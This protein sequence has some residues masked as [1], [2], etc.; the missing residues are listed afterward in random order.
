[1]SSVS[2]YPSFTEL[3]I[4]SFWTKDPLKN[5]VKV[6]DSFHQRPESMQINP[7]PRQFKGLKNAPTSS[8]DPQIQRPQGKNSHSTEC[9]GNLINRNGAASTFLGTFSKRLSSAG[10]AHTPPGRG[11]TD[12]L[13]KE[14]FPLNCEG[15]VHSCSND[16]N[17]ERQESWRTWKETFRVL[18]SKIKY[19]FFYYYYI[20]LSNWF[21]GYW[22][23]FM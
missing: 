20:S 1:M 12:A 15:F 23:S 19:D 17:T 6:K 13:H 10:D 11:L 16:Y 3:A 5:L 18:S 21:L 8:P 14:P 2:N 4:Q 7:F 9:L 22:E